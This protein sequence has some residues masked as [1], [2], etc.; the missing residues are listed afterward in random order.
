MVTTPLFLR[1][2]GGDP[3]GGGVVLLNTALGHVSAREGGGG[4]LRGGAIIN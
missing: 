2:L 4:V 3:P 1:G